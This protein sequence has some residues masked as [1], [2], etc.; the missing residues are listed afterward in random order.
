[1]AQL[2]AQ[3]FDRNNL[4]KHMRT[5]MFVGTVL[6]IINQGQHIISLDFGGIDYFKF[7]LTFLV[8][9]AVSAYAAGTVG[10]KKVNS[11]NSVATLDVEK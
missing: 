3:I 7:I 4:F 2:T 6:N 9:F 8:P 5:S 1:M 11:D 10:N